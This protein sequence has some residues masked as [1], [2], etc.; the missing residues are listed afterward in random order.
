MR[1]EE[2]DPDMKVVEIGGIK[3]SFISV[4]QK[5]VEL[6]GLPFWEQEHKF[7]RIPEAEL[8]N[9]SKN[10]AELATN[11]S[12]V[13]ARFRTDSP[14]VGLR[15]KLTKEPYFGKMPVVGSCGFDVYLGFGLSKRFVSAFGPLD[16]KR[17]LNA[18]CFNYPADFAGDPH[19]RF[20]ET[21]PG[22]DLREVT[23]NFPLYNGVECVEIGVQPGARIEAASPFAIDKPIVFYGSSITQGGC[24]SRPG[25]HYIHHLSRRLNAR[26]VGQGYSGSA[27]AETV[28]A[29]IMTRIPMSVF[30]MDYD[31]NAPTLEY[32]KDTH[33]PFYRYFRERCPDVPVVFVSSPGLLSNQSV[34]LKRRDVVKESY[35]RAFAEGDR[36]ISFVDGSA[37]FSD[38]YADAC[39]VDGC[40]PNDFG[41]YRM[42]D[43][44]ERALREAL[45]L[46]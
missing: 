38:L 10:V 21:V 13:Q 36:R 39:T 4:G 5:P 35:E 27:K 18:I 32:L 15:A 46:R 1:L 37:M 12:C 20:A 31:H 41:F 11:M 25:N 6:N 44:M 26:V 8:P 7:L 43:A 34:F 3:L 23:I 28:M 45:A 29:D 17:E 9:V 40:H 24:A 14:V 33:Y 19:V 42:A 2:I 30:V 16:G 22:T